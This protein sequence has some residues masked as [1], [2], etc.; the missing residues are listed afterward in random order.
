MY[1]PSRTGTSSKRFETELKG[2]CSTSSA[3][4][5]PALQDE[6]ARRETGGVSLLCPLASRRAARVASCRPACRHRSRALRRRCDTWRTSCRREDRH[7][8]HVPAAAL[9]ADEPAMLR[10]INKD[11]VV[12]K[13]QL[14]ERLHRLMIAAEA[15]HSEG[16]LAAA[17]SIAD[18]FCGF[19][20]SHPRRISSQLRW[21]PM[22]KK[23]RQRWSLLGTRRNAFLRT[24]P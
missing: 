17:A 5:R 8:L 14:L 11:H 6:S 13:L 20:T 10:H 2:A 18:G 7:H 15:M 4:A 3:P 23:P 9:A 21:P 24:Q 19:G 12:P 1:P 16:C 22:G